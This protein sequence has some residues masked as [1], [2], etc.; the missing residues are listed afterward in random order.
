MKLIKILPIMIL[1]LACTFV[2]F[3]CSN[4]KSPVSPA[5]DDLSSITNDLPESINADVHNR[6]LLAAY[7]AVIDPVAKTFTISPIERNAQYHFP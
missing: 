4:A 2:S 7:D 5:T 3:A 6:S 1:A